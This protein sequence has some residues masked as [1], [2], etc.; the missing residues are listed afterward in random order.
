MVCLVLAKA[1]R[2]KFGG[3]HIDD[4]RAA[5]ERLQAAHRL[6]AMSAAR[7]GGDRAP[8]GDRLH[9]LHG[10]RQEHRA[11]RRPR[12][13]PGD[14]RDRRPDGA[15]VRDADQAGLR[16]PRRGGLPRA[17]GGD[18]RRPARPGRR[19]RDRARRRQR[20]LAAGPRGARPPHRRLAPGRRRRSLAADRPLRPPPGDQRRRRRPPAARP[21]CR[22]TKSSP[23]RS[24]RRATG[25]SSSGRCRRSRPW[26]S[27]PPGPGCSGPRAPPAS[28]RSWSAAACLGGG[29]W[30][31]EGR[32][33]LV[34][35]R[36]SARSTPVG[37][38]RCEATVEVE[39]GR[40]RRRW[41]KPSGCCASWPPPG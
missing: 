16:A 5:I 1:Y 2:E 24:S 28:T 19:R 13:R 25:G 3:D 23:T 11:R 20:P 18:R 38:C 7:P 41:P 36:A 33:F 26:Q 4:V 21:A 29:W 27:C 14:D 32:R 31:L 40:G 17:R 22:S 34:T 35:D 39:P 8:P 30:P 9:R 12:R 15:R 10:R 37:S 6:A